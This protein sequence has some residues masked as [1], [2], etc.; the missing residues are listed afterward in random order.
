MVYDSRFN[1]LLLYGKYSTNN[2]PNLDLYIYEY[3]LSYNEWH[4]Y[5]VKRELKN[6][7]VVESTGPGQVFDHQ[8]AIDSNNQILY[9][10]GGCRVPD[11]DDAV[12]GIFNFKRMFI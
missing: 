1:R 5:L 9:L 3:K 6:G 12:H 10:F 8:L 4:K 7:V 2:E 11:T